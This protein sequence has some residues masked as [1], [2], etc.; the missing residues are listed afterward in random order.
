[1]SFRTSFSESKV[2][3]SIKNVAKALAT[4]LRTLVSF[5]SPYDRYRYSE[6]ESAISISAKNGENYFSVSG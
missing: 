4:F 6:D 3:V 5:S 1:M 2:K